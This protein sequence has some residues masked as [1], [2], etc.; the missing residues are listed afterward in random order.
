[1]HYLE[2]FLQAKHTYAQS[3]LIQR[4]MR[5]RL[6][7]ILSRTHRMEFTHIFEFGAGN[8]E[9]MRLLTPILHYES[10]I[11]NDINDYGV[12]LR[13]LPNVEYHIFDM[14]HLRN[15]PL[16]QCKFDLILSNASLQWLDFEKSISEIHSILAPNGLCLL[17][18]FGQKNC[19]EVRAITHQ[20]LP[21][22]E[23]GTMRDILTQYFEILYFHDELLSL[24]FPSALDVF[25]HLKQSGVN[26]LQRGGY[27][28]KKMLTEYELQFHNTL[29]YHPIYLLLSCRTKR[30]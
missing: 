6:V 5:H 3:A 13:D 26:A 7:E 12:D 1:M 16:W 15:S 21:Y 23:L 17:S 28:S 29:T 11:C 9:L 24:Q 18:T 19:Y 10:Y 2:R 25:R 22:M 8:G 14:A 27:I 30:I 4:Q 20:G